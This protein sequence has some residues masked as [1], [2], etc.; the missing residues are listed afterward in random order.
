MELVNG[1]RT[2]CITAASPDATAAALAAVPA[3]AVGELRA[4]LLAPDAFRSGAWMSFPER[5]NRPWV[6]TWRSPEEGGRSGAVPPGAYEAALA[7]GYRWVDV[8]ARS[9]A[10]GGPAVAAVPAHRRW[11]SRHDTRPLASAE[12]L[13]HRVAALAVHPA[14]LHKLVVPAHRFVENEY[15][16]DWVRE[17]AVPERSPVSVFAQGTIGHP[18]RVLGGLRGNAVTFVAAGPG[19]GTAEGQPTAETLLVLYRWFELPSDP[20]L[21][22]VV[23]RRAASSR[24]PE[25]HNSAFAA[26]GIPALYLPLECESPDRIEAWLRTGRL[27]GVSVTVPDKPWAASVADVLDESARGIRA[28]NTLRADGARLFGANTDRVTAR[29]LLAELGVTAGSAVAVLGAGGAAAAVAA[30]AADLGAS[31]VLFARDSARARA[32]VGRPGVREAAPMDMLTPAAF[33]AVVNA[34]PLRGEDEMPPSLRATSWAGAAI[35]DLTYGE[36]PGWWEEAAHR[37]GARFRGGL[38]FLVRQGREQ[39]R[40]WT[41]RDP[42]TSSFGSPWTRPEGEV[43]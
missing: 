32:L 27:R 39:F 9:L 2:L 31:C 17:H 4:D 37:D 33:A 28:V 6:F 13:A 23:G 36:E 26:A 14:A 29:E 25:L 3:S 35:L 5:T 7:A 42:D 38:E 16:L 11:V 8:E 43:G 24:S 20:Q 15:S 1:R 10:A 12:D 30:G 34:T 18:S 22:G 40:L 19:A 41:G 21:F